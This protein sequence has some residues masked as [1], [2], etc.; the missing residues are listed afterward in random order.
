MQTYALITDGVV[1]EIISTAQNIATMFHPGLDW[2]NVTD[3]TVTVDTQP[4]APSGIT[5]QSG[6][7]GAPSVLPG[8]NTTSAPAPADTSRPV[9]VGD[10]V[11][12]SGFA[13]PVAPPT[14]NVPTVQQ[15]QADIVRLEAR[16]ARI[17]ASRH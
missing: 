12:G 8:R 9:R 14:P 1:T 15:L 3:I 4:V 10:V 6:S 16:V 5:P 13:V 2:R 7:T 11:S 17:E